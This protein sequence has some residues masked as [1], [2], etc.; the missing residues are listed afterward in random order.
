MTVGRVFLLAASLGVARDDKRRGRLPEAS[1]TK[2]G[3]AKIGRPTQPNHLHPQRFMVLPSQLPQAIQGGHLVRA[4]TVGGVHGQV[5]EA[6]D[7]VLGSGEII[8]VLVVSQWTAGRVF[9]R[10]QRRRVAIR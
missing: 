6:N 7:I 2:Q 3:T 5:V 9:A 8:G 1:G 4:E 10:Q